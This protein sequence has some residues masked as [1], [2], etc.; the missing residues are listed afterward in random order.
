MEKKIDKERRSKNKDTSKRDHHKVLTVAP[1]INN[2]TQ[3]SQYLR[4]EI[5]AGAQ[6][7]AL[8]ISVEHLHIS[9][10]AFEEAFVYASIPK[11]TP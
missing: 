2:W 3:G 11:R 6:A 9:I 1:I 5:R 10:L 8:L 4:R 7:T